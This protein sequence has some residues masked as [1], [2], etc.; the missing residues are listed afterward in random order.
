MTDNEHVPDIEQHMVIMKDQT[1][2]TLRMTKFWNYTNVNDF[3]L[4]KYTLMWLNVFLTKSGVSN[5]PTP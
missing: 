2:S 4:V 5:T 3:E 1:H